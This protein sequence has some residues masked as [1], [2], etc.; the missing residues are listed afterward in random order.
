MRSD[1][2]KIVFFWECRKRH[3]WESKFSKFSRGR[4]P[5]GAQATG[6]CLLGYFPSKCPSTFR[7]KKKPCSSACSFTHLEAWSLQL[8]HQLLEFPHQHSSTWW[9]A[10]TKVIST[11]DFETRTASGSELFSLITRLH[12][13]TFTMLSTFSRLGMISIK[14]GPGDT[15]VLAHGTFSSGCCPRL[16]NAC[17]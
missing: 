16:K 4:I 6:P 14:C 7:I 15:T 2:K 3:S 11:R 5:I 10:S 17:A 12:T 8:L 1:D 13:I 9:W